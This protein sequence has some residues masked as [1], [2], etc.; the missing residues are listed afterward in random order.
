MKFSSIFYCMPY[1][2]LYRINHYKHLTICS[3]SEFREHN[4]EA[5]DI[6]FYKSSTGLHS[7]PGY[8]GH[9][10]WTISLISN[11]ICESTDIF[12]CVLMFSTLTIIL[13]ILS[14]PRVKYNMI[15]YSIAVKVT[16]AFQHQI[17]SLFL[18]MYF[19]WLIYIILKIERGAE[20]AISASQLSWEFFSE[21]QLIRWQMVVT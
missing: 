3:N 16:I 1:G 10:G 12:P 5:G 11:L 21:R 13:R 7:Y 2:T 18:M 14:V 4:C 15:S 20:Q 9:I 19:I 6:H 8:P 17:L